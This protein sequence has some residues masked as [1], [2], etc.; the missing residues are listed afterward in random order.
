M[1]E[2]LKKAIGNAWSFPELTPPDNAKYIGSAY[3]GTEQYHYYIAEG[4]KYYYET[5]SGKAFKLKMA[6]RMLRKMRERRK[7]NEL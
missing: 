3:R 6:D 7:R 1:S 2:E 5:D 4:G